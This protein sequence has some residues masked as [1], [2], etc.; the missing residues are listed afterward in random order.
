ML[1]VFGFPILHWLEDDHRT[2]WEFSL[3]DNRIW[4]SPVNTCGLTDQLYGHHSSCASRIPPTG[5]ATL[6]GH[7]SFLALAMGGK[8]PMSCSPS[9]LPG[10]LCGHA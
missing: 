9:I 3:R 6:Y 10:N 2:A 5:H 7:R 4:P 8:P 1:Y